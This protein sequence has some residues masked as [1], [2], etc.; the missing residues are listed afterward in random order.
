[1]HSQRAP[2][3]LNTTMPIHETTADQMT[4]PVAQP[5]RGSLAAMKEKLL[6]SES[7]RAD[8]PAAPTTAP[9]P[10]SPTGRR[11]SFAV[12]HDKLTFYNEAHKG[13]PPKVNVRE[14]TAD[15]LLN[16]QQHGRRSSFARM[17]EMIGGR[18]DERR[19]SQERRSGEHR[20]LSGG[21]RANPAHPDP[22]MVHHEQPRHEHLRTHKDN[23]GLGEHSQQG[24][25]SD[26]VNPDGTPKRRDSNSGVTEGTFVGQL[27]R[28]LSASLD[29]AMHPPK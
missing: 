23:E 16:A 10:S 3:L 5:R 11:S 20:R 28:R 7:P 8:K 27:G 9:A 2:P 29:R 21:A 4:T 17:Q 14:A 19:K 26:I 24:N 12:M 25:T 22:G 1:M 15:E 13:P 6:G 18:N